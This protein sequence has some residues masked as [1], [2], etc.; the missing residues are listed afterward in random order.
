MGPLAPTADNPASPHHCLL[1][2]VWC[3]LGLELCYASLLIKNIAFREFARQSCALFLTCF[4]PY[5]ILYQ[6]EKYNTEKISWL[7]P[8]NVFCGQKPVLSVQMILILSTSLGNDSQKSV[9][10]KWMWKWQWKRLRI[11][12]CGSLYFNWGFKCSVPGSTYSL[13]WVIIINLWYHKDLNFPYA[14]ETSERE[15]CWDVRNI[16]LEVWKQSSS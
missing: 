11:F 1:I 12:W 16:S 2:N 13:D 14:E 5:Q 15:V 4:I 9:I 3:Q 7:S 8:W 6:R 10:R